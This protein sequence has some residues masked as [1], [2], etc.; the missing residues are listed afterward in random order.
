MHKTRIAAISPSPGDGS[1]FYRGFGAL[2]KLVKDEGCRRMAN[3]I[4]KDQDQIIELDS[5]DSWGWEHL[6]QADL[7]FFQRPFMPA[8]KTVIQMAKAMSIPVWVDYD[9]DLF[10]VTWSNPAY[11]TFMTQTVHADILEILE[12]ADAITVSTA[13]MKTDSV[14]G[15]IPNKTPHVVRNAIDTDMFKVERVM[16]A[17][18]KAITWRGSSTHFEDMAP[19]V[20]AFVETAMFN[21]DW[22]FHFIGH[23]HWE[24]IRKMPGDQINCIQFI[25]NIMQ[26]IGT[27]CLLCPA[28]HVVTLVDNQFNRCK[29]NIAA[30]EAIYAGAMVVAPAGFAEWDMPGVLNY[31]PGCLRAALQIAI[32]NGEDWRADMWYQT[33]NYVLEELSLRNVNK[34]RATLIAMLTAK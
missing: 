18:R 5:R 21:K 29:S 14:F 17:R 27:L 32:S 13:H 30:L 25:D 33:R 11:Q 15:K 34:Q 28:I 1:S 4:H 3:T 2:S 8:H 19:N 9:D 24:L 20:D 22:T 12:M 31:E 7:L 10:N 23:P 16:E 26:F 6:I